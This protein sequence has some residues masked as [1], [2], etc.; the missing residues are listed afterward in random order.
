SL[1][2]LRHDVIRL[3]DAL[4]ALDVERRNRQR[5][6][7]EER[8]NERDE[9]PQQASL[10]CRVLDRERQERA[11]EGQEGDVRLPAVAQDL[12]A[13]RLLVGGTVED[14]VLL[15]R[16][17]P[18]PPPLEGFYHGR[19]ERAR[20]PGLDG[21]RAARVASPGQRGRVAD[22]TGRLTLGVPR[23]RPPRGSRAA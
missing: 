6:G 4:V 2:Q 16:R 5:E 8:E 7:D 14:L 13:I 12:V 11:V 9:Q 3:V 23:T 19:E 22:P 21:Q 1:R 15:F 20:C 17:N 10:G 18:P